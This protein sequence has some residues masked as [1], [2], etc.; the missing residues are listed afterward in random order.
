MLETPMRELLAEYPSARRALFSHFHIG[1]CQSC[2]F[3]EDDSLGAVCKQHDIDAEK[4]Q[5]AIL[6]SHEEEQALLITPGVLAKKLAAAEPPVLV[7]SRTR[8]EHDAVAIPGSILLVESTLAELSQD[9]EQEIVFYDHRG[10]SVLDHVSWFRGHGLKNTFALKGGIDAY[11]Q[12]VDPALPR[13][14]LE[15]D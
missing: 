7:D 15:I 6:T 5:Q 12:D 10:L 1:G 2:A 13:Y 3:S 11:S 9:V 8:E 4:A 14:R